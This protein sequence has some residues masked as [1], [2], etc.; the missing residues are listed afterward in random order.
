MGANFAIY[1]SD[2]G[3]TSRNYREL[4]F[5]RKKQLHQKVVKDMNRH[6]SKE[7]TYAANK[8]E[9]KLVFTSH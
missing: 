3:L 6:F 5:T 7:D 8:H 2:K 4:K 1:L 9:K